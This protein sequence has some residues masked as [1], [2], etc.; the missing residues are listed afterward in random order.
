MRLN[1]VTKFCDCINNINGYKKIKP[2]LGLGS[3]DVVKLNQLSTKG[4]LCGIVD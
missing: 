4:H 1:E 3:A 2:F